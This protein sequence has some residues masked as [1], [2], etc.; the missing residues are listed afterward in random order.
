MAIR[1]ILK[2][3][4]YLQFLCLPLNYHS[5]DLCK[6]TEWKFNG[7]HENFKYLCFF[8]Q[9]CNWL[10]HKS[11]EL[12]FGWLQTQTQT[13]PE[14]FRIPGLSLSPVSPPWLRSSLLV[15]P[16]D[17][18]DVALMSFPSLSNS[19]SARLATVL[20]CS[21][22]SRSSWISTMIAGRLHLNSPANTIRKNL[23]K[24]SSYFSSIVFAFTCCE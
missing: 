19:S 7:T 9:N 1:S 22:S 17:D 15:P 3:D 2:K 4:N 11:A 21:V 20:I 13:E 23:L 8:F 12:P 14:Q 24:K 5:A 10:L 16:W 18:D 6:L